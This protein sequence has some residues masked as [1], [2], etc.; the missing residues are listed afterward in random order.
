MQRRNVDLPEPDGPSRHMTSLGRDLQRDALED[1][2]APEALAD[3]LGA[4][5]RVVH[6]R[7]PDAPEAS[8]RRVRGT[9]SRCGAAA[10]AGVGGRLREAPR[11]KRRST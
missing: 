2:E 10:G 9:S 8:T 7:S 11:P 5:H 6:R 4:D 1:L 3:R